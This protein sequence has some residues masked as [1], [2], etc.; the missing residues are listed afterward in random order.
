MKLAIL[1][2]GRVRTRESLDALRR[3]WGRASVDDRRQ[4][5]AEVQ[6][7]ALAP[8]ADSASPAIG[9]PT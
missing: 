5:L 2:K 9:P 6:G 1:D 3:A 8:D 4:F 7:T